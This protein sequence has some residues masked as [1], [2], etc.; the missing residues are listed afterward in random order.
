MC[1]C[2]YIPLLFLRKEI[3]YPVL[4]ACFGCEDG[5]SKLPRRVLDALTALSSR[6]SDYRDK[7]ASV[8]DT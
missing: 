2:I 1:F 6:N 4:A 5:Y 7:I 3:H 8:R